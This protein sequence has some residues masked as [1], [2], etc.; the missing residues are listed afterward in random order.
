MSQWKYKNPIIP[1]KGVCDPHVHVFEDKVYLYASHDRSPKSST[2]LMDDWQIWSSKDMI[3]WDY[4]YTFRPEDTYIGKSEICWAVD[5]ACRNGK[6]YYYFSH[7]NHDTGVAVSDNPAGPFTEVLGEPILPEGLTPTHSYDPTV[8]IDPDT[9][10]PY[11]I[12]GGGMGYYIARL[13]EDMISLAEEPK[14]LL[15]DGGH[16]WDDK[17]FIHKKNGIYYLTWASN[18]ATSDNIYGPYVTRGNLG[19]SEDHGSY[20]SKDGQDFAAFTILDPYRFYRAVGLC[21]VHYRANGEI[22][23]EDLI[24]EYG[25]GHY[26][27]DWRKIK[28]AWYMKTK[29]TEKL[30]NPWG[31]FDVLIQSQD[32]ELY[33]PKVHGLK[34]KKNIYFW[35]NCNKPEGTYIHVWDAKSNELLGSCRFE[36]TG[37]VSHV[38][39][40]VYGCQLNLKEDT[41]ERDIRFTFEGEG[42]NLL[43]FHWFKFA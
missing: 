27:A 33:F 22:V 36:Y 3:Q 8:F 18:Y 6:Y 23:A 9:D 16:A 4:E 5:A 17:N 40:E 37:K 19:I 30:E 25:V 13:N 2:W 41:D 28:A 32:S 15:L 38:G 7:G 12:W 42:E 39:Y 31:G 10:I 35:A 43:R 14:E 24:A 21:Y 11:I 26:D 29:G 1:G 20:F 34:G